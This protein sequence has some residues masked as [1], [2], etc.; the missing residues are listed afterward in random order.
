MI[1]T[2]L[3]TLF[4]V[5][6]QSAYATEVHIPA[7]C[8]Q[9]ATFRPTERELNLRLLPVDQHDID[10]SMSHLLTHSPVGRQI[11]S[12]LFIC[13]S[14]A[15]QFHLGLSSNK[16]HEITGRDCRSKPLNR[17]YYLR[18]KDRTHWTPRTYVILPHTLAEKLFAW[19]YLEGNKV[20]LFTN[21]DYLLTLAHELAIYVDQTR[22]SLRL[23]RDPILDFAYRALRA[24]KL[25]HQ[26]L[27]IEPSKPLEVESV[28]RALHHFAIQLWNENRLA[29][30]LSVQDQ[31]QD[32]LPLNCPDMLQWTSRQL[33]R[34]KTT[35]IT[36]GSHE[37]SLHEA[38]SQPRLEPLNPQDS[39]HFRSTS[40]PRPRIGGDW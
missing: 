18:P 13:D 6:A 5:V 33:T 21:K 8:Q 39:V 7:V 11:L 27:G 36:H 1:V 19:T 24:E 20:V 32:T 4:M 30:M 26:L 38:L 35:M 15:L 2:P 9:Q 10:Q 17:T 22:D 25:A 34:L 31:T 40:G 12:Q 3:S 14:D 37:L 28:I 23:T 16:A 29:V